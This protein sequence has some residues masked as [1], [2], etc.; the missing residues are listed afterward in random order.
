M[1]RFFTRLGIVIGILL[2]LVAFVGVILYVDAPTRYNVLII[3]SDQRSDEQGRSDVLMVFS[4]P[5]SPSEQTSLLTI[6]RDTRVDVPGYGTQK[7][8]HAYALGERPEGSTLGNRALTEETI[9][10]LLDIPIHATLEFTFD[11]FQRIIDAEGG[12]DTDTGHLDGAEAL[13]LVRN[14]FREGGDFART[15][16]Q[17]DVFLSLFRSVQ[18]IDD[19][20]R[21]LGYFQDGDGADVTYAPGRTIQ[22]GFATVLRRFGNLTIRDVRTEV[23]PGTGQSIYTAEFGK[24]LYYWVPD[25]D[26]FT[27][28]R[29]E[30]YE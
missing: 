22:F 3:G 16:D 11:S 24:E 19:V 26:A 30:L 25:D 27:T 10:A 7:I 1:Q 23:V 21:F 2:V 18:T 15:E 17:R 28:L 6:P 12:V 13:T 14:R 29:A 5:K 9:E 4:L 8:T 20:R